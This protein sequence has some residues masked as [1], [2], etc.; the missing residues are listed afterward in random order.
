MRG[1]PRRFPSSDGLAECDCMRTANDG[2]TSCLTLPQ[3]SR[4]AARIRHQWNT[5]E[6]LLLLYQISYSR[7]GIPTAAPSL[8]AYTTCS[9]EC[10]AIVA[11]E[12][13]SSGDVPTN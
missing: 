6:T 2:T 5:C 4:T 11:A 1:D 12:C 3:F 10:T 13:C 7:H 9:S 8:R